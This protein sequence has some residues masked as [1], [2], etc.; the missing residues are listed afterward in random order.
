MWSVL[1]HTSLHT[2][3][4]PNTTCSPS[5]KFSPITMTMAPPVVQPS[6]GLMALIHGVARN[7]SRVRPTSLVW[8]DH[9]WSLRGHNMF[10]V[11]VF[12]FIFFWRDRIYAWMLGPKVKKKEVMS[13]TVDIHC[14]GSTNTIKGIKVSVEPGQIVTQ[15]QST[16]S[17]G[18]IRLQWRRTQSDKYRRDSRILNWP[19]LMR[20]CH[21]INF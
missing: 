1:I 7:K 11:C 15:H 19:Y 13:K 14:G 3:M 12:I 18:T 9:S 4:L 16:S 17:S 21:R 6:L 10:L 2:S 8:F 5:K 20:I